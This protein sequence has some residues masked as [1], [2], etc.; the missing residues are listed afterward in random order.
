MTKPWFS[1]PKRQII[2]AL[3][4]FRAY[5]KYVSAAKSLKKAGYMDE[6]SVV[7]K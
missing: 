5:N 2:A 4:F 6:R 1:V 3:K 7:G